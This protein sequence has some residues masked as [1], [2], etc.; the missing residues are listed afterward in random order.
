MET[1]AAKNKDEWL[2]WFPELTTLLKHFRVTEMRIVVA[3]PRN[4]DAGPK[5]FVYKEKKT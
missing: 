1:H 5:T 4:E 3:N 2:K